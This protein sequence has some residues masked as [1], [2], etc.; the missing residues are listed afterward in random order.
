MNQIAISMALGFVAALAVSVIIV[1]TRRWHG[2]FTLDETEGVQK[3]HALPTPRIGGV[4]VLVGVLT[5]ALLAETGTQQTLLIIAVCGAPAFLF[6]LA[7]DITRR[8]SVRARLLATMAAGLIFCIVTGYA[9]DRIDIWGWDHALAIVPLAWA[10][11][12]FAMGGVANSVNIIDG[13]HG[14]STGTV[15]VMLAGF[16]L[17]ASSQKDLLLTDLSLILLAV[18]AGVFVVNFPLGKLFLGDAGAYYLGF[19]LAAIAVMLPVRNPDVSPWVSLMICAYP[20]VE[21]VYSM[22]RRRLAGQRTG[23]PDN[24]HLH[25]LLHARLLRAGW[26]TANPMAAVMLWSLPILSFGFILTGNMTTF[27]SILQFVGFF[28]VYRLIYAL[29][30]RE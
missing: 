12:A 17:I 6:G 19:L 14:L 21:T 15:M 27:A 25:Q 1:L 4:S 23:E 8:V 20:I 9:V 29:V 7:E 16:A 22:W 3:L 11:S 2:A 24:A 30:S 18:T 13:L 26:K 28:V 10:F 5:A